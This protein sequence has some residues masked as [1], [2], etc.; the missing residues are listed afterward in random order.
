MGQHLE[1]LASISEA[2]QIRC[3]LAED[4]PDSFLP[5]LAGSLGNLSGM[6]KVMG[7]NED[8]LASIVEAISILRTLVESNPD[9]FLPTLATSIKDLAHTRYKLG[10]YAEAVALV[11]EAVQIDTGLAKKNPSAFLPALADSLHKQA[12]AHT[13]MG[14]ALRLEHAREAL[15]SITESVRLHKEIAGANPD[16]HALDLAN[17]L[18]ELGNCLDQVGRLDEA[19]NATAES[20]RVLLPLFLAKPP[21]RDVAAEQTVL[22]YLVRS[23]RL[24]LEPDPQ[25]INQFSPLFLRKAIM[26]QIASLAQQ[27]MDVIAP[28]LPLAAS[29]AATQAADGFLRQPGAKLYDWLV[30]KLKG[31]PAAAVLTTGTAET[32]NQLQL[33][34]LRLE[35]EN[36]AGSDLEFRQQLADLL[37]EVAGNST[38]TANQTAIQTGDNNKGAQASGIK[39][40]IHIG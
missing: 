2:I 31:T 27:A 40:S 25:L 3:A 10:Q 32:D 20:L 14:E 26:V 7:N 22:Q 24:G 1:A 13:A 23:N 15:A 21:L 38:A 17:S 16:V 29:H 39:I 34:A 5:D 9:A 6:Q 30:T 12:L 8:A 28:L 19:R 36:M 11:A 33:D 4:N 35:I 37:K 18:S